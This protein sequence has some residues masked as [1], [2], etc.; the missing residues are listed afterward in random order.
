MKRLS[1]SILA[2]VFAAAF[3]QVAVALAQGQGAT[4]PPPASFGSPPSG[5]IPILFNDH[6]V[7]AKPDTLKQG[8]VLA[9]L[10]RGGTVLDPAAIDVRADGCDGFLRRR[11]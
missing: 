1:V 4:M 9:A 6:H 5:Q 11:E 7:Y 2:L 10:V 8:R 3:S